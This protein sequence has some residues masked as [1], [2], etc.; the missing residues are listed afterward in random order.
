[1]SG[2]VA[3]IHIYIRINGTMNAMFE[4]VKSLRLINGL[5]CYP[6]RSV[7]MNPDI[8]DPCYLSKSK[9]EIELIRDGLCSLHFLML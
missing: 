5:F 2:K 9:S 6:L 1:M 4:H 3:C 8:V 7:C